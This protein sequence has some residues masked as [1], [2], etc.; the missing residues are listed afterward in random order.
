MTYLNHPTELSF[1]NCWAFG[2]VKVY[3]DDNEIAS[4]GPVSHKTVI[5]DFQEGAVLSIRDEG[6]NSIIQIDRFEILTCV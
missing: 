4:A 2:I 6:A 1:G 3:L 5:F